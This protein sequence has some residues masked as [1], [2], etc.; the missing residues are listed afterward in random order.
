M[1]VEVHRVAR[2]HPGDLWQ[3]SSGA[4]V[5]VVLQRRGGA[6]VVRPAAPEDGDVVT[7]P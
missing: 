1:L 5:E 7:V 2:D 6:G 3:R 4:V